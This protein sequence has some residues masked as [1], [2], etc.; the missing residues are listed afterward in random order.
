MPTHSR[1]AGM[2]IL[3]ENSCLTYLKDEIDESIQEAVVYKR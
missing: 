3:S 2:C 1:K